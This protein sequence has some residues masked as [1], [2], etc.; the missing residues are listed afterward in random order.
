MFSQRAYKDILPPSSSPVVQ[1][2]PVVV[3][4]VVGEGKVRVV[5]DM[6]ESRSAILLP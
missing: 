6:N 2:R 5:E 4:M 3:V 1:R